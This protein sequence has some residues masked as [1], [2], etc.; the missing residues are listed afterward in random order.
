LNPT[1]GSVSRLP[2]RTRSVL[3]GIA[4]LVLSGLWAAT[5]HASAVKLAVLELRN[6]A[7]LSAAEMAYLT[8]RVRG[9]ASQ[10]LPSSAYLVMT[11]ESIQEL[12]P[13]GVKLVDCLS[14]QC[15]V[16]VGRKIGADY[17]VTGE[18][19]KFGDE[20][21]M[22]LKVH[23]CVSGAFLGSETA[24]GARLA[25]LENGVAAASGRLFA[26]VR[27]H[28]GA[29]EDAEWRIGAAAP[30]TW[31]P[32]E[33]SAT[34]VDFASDPAGAVV[35]VDGRV[36][37][38][39]TPCSRELPA[40]AAMVMMRKERYLPNQEVVEVTRRGPPLKLN[41]T[42]EP[43]FGW[44]TVTSTPPGLP[45]DINGK[46]AG[47]T[48]IAASEL[49]PGAHAVRIS[50]PR[51]Y[52]RG[53][54]VVLARGEK[55]TVSLAPDPREGAIRVSA[56][57][58]DS[59]A[60]AARVFLDGVEVG[61]TPCTIKALIGRHTI[62]AQLDGTQWTDSVQVA[63]RQVVTVQGRMRK[64]APALPRVHT[65]GPAGALARGQALLTKA[66]GRAGGSVAWAAIMSISV[67]RAETASIQGQTR[68]ITSVM[69]WR[70]PDRYVVTRKLVLG[71]FARGYDGTHGWKADRGQV[72]DDP[73]TGE[74]LRRQ[75]ERSILRLFAEPGAFQVQALDE[76]RTVDGVTYS[77]ALVKSE[78]TRDWLLYF[79]PDGSLARMEYQGEGVNGASVRTTEIYGDWKPVI[80]RYPLRYPLRYPR[81]E[82][83][84]PRSEQTLMDGQTVMDARVTSVK[85]NPTL[86]DDLF[87]KPAK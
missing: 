48:P 41:W 47:R 50:D 44:L 30:D 74:E 42:L 11:R 79:A 12:L 17:I 85:L 9:D 21:R 24:G 59:N 26:K 29:G 35:I 39:G 84:Y 14:S 27:T 22:N 57:G 10:A 32:P 49:A 82:I 36:V 66:A 34:V 51:Y 77:V 69:Q 28:A 81:S 18:I 45:V 56:R 78:T 60:V 80:D 83:R 25:D 75:Y 6:D 76:S 20:L 19:L 8:D 62:T 13:P 65:D 23:H 70:I 7:G 4:L 53:E 72:R 61:T 58:A 33:D 3:A 64:V 55:R 86:A 54:R 16:E 37:C 73:G 52:E 1:S 38:Q 67:T 43:N 5:A 63:E 46:P 15:E 71:E 2:L 40:G 68:A 87:R 31:S